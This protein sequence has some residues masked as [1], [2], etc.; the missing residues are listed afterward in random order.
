MGPLVDRWSVRGLMLIGVGALA[1]AL[2][3]MSI[4]QGAIAF[5]ATTAVLLGSA[6]VLLGP[7]TGSAIVARWFQE[8]RGRALGISAAGTSVGGMLVPQLLGAGFAAVGWR[9]SLQVL[10]AAVLVILVP[11]LIFRFRDHPESAPVHAP[12]GGT[13]PSAATSRG[14]A[15]GAPSSVQTSVLAGYVEIV[16]R[17]DFWML[18]LALAFFITGCTAVLANLGAFAKDLGVD[19]QQSKHLM[20]LLAGAGLLSKLVMGELLDRVPLRLALAGA[21]LATISAHLVFAS[22]PTGI[23]LSLGAVLLG[24]SSGGM[25][26]VW[27]ALVAAVFGVARFGQVMG[28]MGPVIG[29][30]VA[31]G[32]TV[33]GAIREATGSYVP[34]LQVFIAVLVVALGLVAFLRVPQRPPAV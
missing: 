12:A 23:G 30:L 16:R 4:A 21:I 19:V 9:A 15:P 7:T 29:L 22:E 24:I 8:N 10:A 2:F 31:P 5:V 33:A 25:L 18:T 34:V 14:P 3:G 28:L 11:L 13:T 27:G 17:P 1:G 6:T 20:S 26:P 32:Y